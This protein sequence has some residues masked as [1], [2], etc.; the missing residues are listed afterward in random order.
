MLLPPP[1][2]GRAG[3]TASIVAIETAAQAV[4]DARA[5][6]PGATLADLYDPLTMPPDLTQAHR[7]LDA[8]V[9]AAYAKKKF[10]GDADRVAFLFELYRR[11]AGNSNPLDYAGE[12]A[13]P[14]Y[15]D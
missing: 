12:P 13:N 6:H 10:T 14:T 3:G 5:N 4:L 11:L 9:D 8:A 7:M 1:G 2:G 15:P